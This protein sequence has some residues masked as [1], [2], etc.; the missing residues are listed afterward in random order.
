[1]FATKANIDVVKGTREK[2]NRKTNAK[3]ALISSIWLRFT[4]QPKQPIATCTKPNVKASPLLINIELSKWLS[5]WKKSQLKDGLVWSWFSVN[6]QP[7]PRNME[8][9]CRPFLRHLLLFF[10]FF[11]FLR[12]FSNVSRP[13]DCRIVLS[14]RSSPL[15][16]SLRA[17]YA[18]RRCDSGDSHTYN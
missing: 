4:R 16:V 15:L 1:M 8:F 3:F 14:R 17:L 11:F 7:I 10:S 9:I 13:Q 5:K 6:E 12:L 18:R 2:P